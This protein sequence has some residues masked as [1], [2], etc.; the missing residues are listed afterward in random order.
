MFQQGVY[1]LASRVRRVAVVLIAPALALAC[2]DSSGPGEPVTLADLAATRGAT[3]LEWT[4]QGGSG[5]RFDFI[6]N[7][8]TLQV[9]ISTTGAVTGSGSSP[10]TGAFTISGTISVAGDIL[11]VGL[12]ATAENPSAP[13]IV[14]PAR[15]TFML[16]GNDW[17]RTSTEAQF[18]FD[19]DGTPEPATLIVGLRRAG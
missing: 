18:D 3:R 16:A 10:L 14:F 4:A 2:G 17:T 13:T 5:Q 11:N 12:T 15:F 8:G 7:G 1:S 9:A 19:F 6:A